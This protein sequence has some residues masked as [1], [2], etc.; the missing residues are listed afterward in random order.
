MHVY[1]KIDEAIKQNNSISF[2][3]FG[4]FHH[5]FKEYYLS[6]S[7]KLPKPIGE[8]DSTPPN[9]TREMKDMLKVRNKIID[10]CFKDSK[11]LKRPI[12]K[13]IMYFNMPEFLISLNYTPSRIFPPNLEHTAPNAA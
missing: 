11:I 5:N 9:N 13:V 6:H 1:N 3:V 7:R 12:D 2:S 8:V 4:Q 10:T